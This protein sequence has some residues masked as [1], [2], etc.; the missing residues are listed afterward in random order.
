MNAQQIIKL[1]R[2]EMLRDTLHKD[3]L[4]KNDKKTWWQK[5]CFPF[6]CRKKITA[7]LKQPSNQS[8]EG[9]ANAGLQNIAG[10][11]SFCF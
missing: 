7:K 9:R 4:L 2:Q 1:P 6:C 5:W 3:I 10:K 11:E 8:F